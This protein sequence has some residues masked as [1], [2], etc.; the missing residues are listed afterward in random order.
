[1]EAI[2]VFNIYND[3]LSK[4]DFPV[5]LSALSDDVIW[6]QPGTH[7]F[8]GVFTGVENVGEH[9]GQMAGETQGTLMLVTEW[10]AATDNIVTAS[11]HFTAKRGDKSIDMMEIDVFRIE[12]DKIAEVWLVDQ[13]VDLENDFWS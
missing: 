3:G 1:M 4:G 2:E 5:A 6:H 9:L 10:A 13:N 11:V 8:A 12:N 7:Q